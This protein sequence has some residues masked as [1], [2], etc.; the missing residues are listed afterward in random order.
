M[1]QVKFRIQRMEYILDY[2]SFIAPK[3][4]HG[5]THGFPNVGKT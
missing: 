5:N 1:I 3:R 2:Y 4:Q